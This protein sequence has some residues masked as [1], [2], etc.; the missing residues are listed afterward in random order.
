MQPRQ[1]GS[2]AD[3]TIFTVLAD[4]ARRTPDGRLVAYAAGGAVAVVA[5]LLLVPRLWPAAAPCLV[6]CAFGTW[7]IADRE[8]S[9]A[10]PS[11]GDRSARVIAL[12]TAKSAAA[13]LGTVAAI[14]SAIAGLA[15][16]LGRVIS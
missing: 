14:A 11:D 6:V 4:R 8:L 13:V 9:E 10:S 7:G 15:V 2:T 1:S 5:L 16:A 12:R 3:E